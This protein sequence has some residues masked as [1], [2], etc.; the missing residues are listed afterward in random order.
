MSNRPIPNI[1]EA[2]EMLYATQNESSPYQIISTTRDLY[3]VY[4]SLVPLSNQILSKHS[5]GD[6]DY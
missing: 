5:L 1:I 2:G 6:N 4:M 3:C